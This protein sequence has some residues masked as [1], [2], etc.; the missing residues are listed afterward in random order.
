MVQPSGLTLPN[1]IGR[2]FFL[3]MDD[4]MGK[5]GLSQLLD[6]AQ[7]S[8]YLDN[9][10]PDNLAREFDF[11]SLSALNQ[12]LEEMYGER[13]GRGMALRVGRASFAKGLKRFGA[14]RGIA[15]PAF[16]A[17]PLA[18]RVDYGLRGLVSIYNHFSDQHTRLEESTADY[19]LTIEHCPM[20]WGRQADKPI[21]HAQVGILQECL[22]WASNGYEYH[23]REVA[24]HATGAPACVFQIRKA[25]IGESRRR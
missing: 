7:L 23:I 15:D 18:Q 11:A 9:Y 19:T 24:C 25:A 4:V 14:M 6:H 10:P 21:C 17:L 2:A 8:T 16:R 3:A 5:Y 1:R 20:A 13:G 12:G 22:R